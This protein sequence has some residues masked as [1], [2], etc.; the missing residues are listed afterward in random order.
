MPWNL[1]YRMLGMVQTSSVLRRP[2]SW[3]TWRTFP[4]LCSFRLGFRRPEI[5]VL[6]TGTWSRVKM[7]MKVLRLVF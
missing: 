6:S 4:T 2:S 5:C 1:Q 7:L 3:V